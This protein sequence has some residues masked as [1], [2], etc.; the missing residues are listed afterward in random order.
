MVMGQLMSI[1][2]VPL[3]VMMVKVV[4]EILS[5][6]PLELLGRSDTLKISTTPMGNMT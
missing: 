5:L 1:K 3:I 4:K 2:I 6:Y